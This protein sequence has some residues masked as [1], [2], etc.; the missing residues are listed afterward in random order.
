LS[1]GEVLLD[2]APA[3]NPEDEAWREPL[4]VI[5]MCPDCKEYPP[6]LVEVSMSLQ[7]KPSGRSQY[8]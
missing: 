2:E 8:T 1:P 7:T 4:D 6:N 5:M 3:T